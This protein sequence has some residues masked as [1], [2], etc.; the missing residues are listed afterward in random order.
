MTFFFI[1]THSIRQ[2]ADHY[3]IVDICVYRLIVKETSLYFSP[4]L[5][6]VLFIF[7]GIFVS[8]PSLMVDPLSF[9]SFHP[10]LHAWFKKG[11]DMY[12]P[13]CEMVH[14]KEPL[15]L[16]GKC[17][18]CRGCHG[19]PRSLSEWPFTIMFDAI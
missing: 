2:Y 18:P 9:F 10:V 15:L 6:I 13:V 5:S 1:S 7:P 3:V 14:I 12:Y 17:N 16:I 4:C 8:L 19:F 11:C